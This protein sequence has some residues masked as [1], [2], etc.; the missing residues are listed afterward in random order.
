MSS[1][2]QSF[3]GSPYAQEFI[4]HLQPYST[5]Y[6]A[7]RGEQFDLQVNGQGMCYLLLEGTIAFYRRN[8][9]MMLTTAR[10]PAIFGLANMTDIYFNDYF[11]TVTPCLR[12]IAHGARL[13][14]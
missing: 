3:R 7:G 4:S 2:N 13:P 10:S 11:K 9:G 8:D 12:P 14:G 6:K 1:A 5:T